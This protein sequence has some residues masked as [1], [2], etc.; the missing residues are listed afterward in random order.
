[1]DPVVPEG[2]G[3]VWNF[4]GAV[5]ST[6][7]MNPQSASANTLSLSTAPCSSRAQPSSSTATCSRPARAAS[8]PAGFPRRQRR[9][10]ASRTSPSRGTGRTPHDAV[11]VL[12]RR[13]RQRDRANSALRPACGMTHARRVQR[14]AGAV[15][16]LV[17]VSDLDRVALERRA[18]V[19]AQLDLMALSPQKLCHT[20]VQRSAASAW[21]TSTA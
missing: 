4:S 10:P 13:Y 3:F 11:H 8:P 21:D 5:I 18:G 12:D 1:M 15:V 19:G 6:N 7:G 14:V 2:A 20:V 9:P 17:G 16:E